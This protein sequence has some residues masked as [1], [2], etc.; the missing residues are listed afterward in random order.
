MHT[1][2]I[3]QIQQ[4]K[5]RTITHKEREDKEGHNSTGD[6]P[7]YKILIKWGYLARGQ[8]SS[9]EESEVEKHGWRPMLLKGQ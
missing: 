5:H 9:P 1:E 3:Q 6:A 8:S 7:H 2:K 4:N